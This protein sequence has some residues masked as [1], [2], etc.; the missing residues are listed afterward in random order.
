[1][2]DHHM[3]KGTQYASGANYDSSLVKYWQY[4][5]RLWK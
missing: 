2:Y 4:Y 3:V 1:M 5:W